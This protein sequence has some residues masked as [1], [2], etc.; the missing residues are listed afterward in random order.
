[1]NDVKLTL[2]TRHPPADNGAALSAAATKKKA[3]IETIEDAWI[4]ILAMKNSDGDMQRLR[5]V[6]VAMDAGSIGRDSPG[7]RFSKA[8]VLRLWRI[9]AESQ[10]EGKLADM[11]AGTPDNYR[12]V[13][14]IGTVYQI[15]TMCRSERLIAVD[16]ETTGLDIYTDVI[17]GISFTLPTYD[18]HYYIPV[19][20]T[21]DERALP[22]D[23]VLDVL[24]PMLE[25]ADIGKV[26]HNANYD[27]NMFKRHGIELAGLAWDTQPAMALL[28]ENEPSFALKNLATRYLNEPSD[29][30]VELFGR[31]AKFAEIPLDVALVYGA[32]DTDITWRL[33]EFQR[34]HLARM[35][36]TRICSVFPS[37]IHDSRKLR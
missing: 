15:A 16:T 7:K 14:D 21:H 11:V 17:V 19:T 20:P 4:R 24:K 1:L 18:T 35:P 13:T 31:D 36:N 3:S 12:L 32:K 28:N 2:N 5:A 8:E 26:F 33:Y 6:K 30:F 34:M 25:N 37:C 23:E 27:I 10:R 22:V 29:T 9:L